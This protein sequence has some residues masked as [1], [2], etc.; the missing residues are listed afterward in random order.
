VARVR[1]RVVVDVTL[2]VPGLAEPAIG[3]LIS[4]PARHQALLND[5]V[6]RQ[7]RD[8]APEQRQEVLV[9]E[10]FAAANRLALGDTVGAIMNGRWQRLRIVGIALSPEYVYEIRGAGDIFPDNKRFGVLW[11]NREALAAAF[12][13]EGA[14]NDVALTLVPGAREAAVIFALDQ[15][16]GRYGGLGAY[17]RYEQISHRFI[18]DEMS[19]LRAN[20]TIMPTIFLG[21]AA[22]LLHVLLARLIKTQRDQIAIL[23]AFGYSNVAIGW[24]YLGFVLVVVCIG[25]ILGIALGLWL[26]SGL[27]TNYGRFFRFPVLHY[28]AGFDLIVLAVLISGGAAGVGA[29]VAVRHATA[30]PPAEA[31]RPEPPARFHTTVLERLGFQRLLSP[32]GRMLWRNLE[33][34]PLQT[35]LS[36]LGIAMAVAMLVV[37]NYFEDALQH[38]MNVQFRQTQREDMTVVFNEPRSARARYEVANL[39]GVLRAESFRTVPVRLRFAHWEKRGALLGLQPAGELRRL[40]DRR[41]HVVQVPTA[42]VVLTTKLADLLHVRP[43]QMLTVEVLQ[44]ARPV[45]RVPVV[46]LVDELIGTSAYM[47]IGA[48]NRLLREGSTV[49]GAYLAIDAQV[50]P[51]LY[52]R[53]KRLPA[54]AGVSFRQ[55]VLQSFNDTAAQNMRVFVQVLV[56]FACIITLSVIYNAARIALSE[57][58]RELASLRVMG[59]T[60]AEIAV[61]LLGE[62]A[63]I[64]LMAIPVGFTLGFGI[65]AL[66]PLAY[67]SELFRLPLVVTKHT[68]AFAFLVVIIAALISGLIVRRRLD[69]LDLIAVLKTR[70]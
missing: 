58:G 37:G 39:R 5:I 22:F 49:S 15:L 24:H 31:M 45:R 54:V 25:A 64:T 66:M 8:I 4:L 68:Y 10:T 51:T 27:T 26:G 63:I 40:I 47:D 32:V 48:L 36:I 65:C 13:L 7:G 59:F 46:G 57:R 14:F 41:L 60:R 67:D 38:I 17:G 62:Q 20:A 44:G 69:H 16:L 53:L 2:D 11:M 19:S 30:L 21:I 55:S 34:K 56:V 6:L 12:N 3:R 29:L 42:G 1:T 35:L 23:K 33:R 43:G 50:A 70:E 28:Q 9:S 52:Q 61:I 18:T